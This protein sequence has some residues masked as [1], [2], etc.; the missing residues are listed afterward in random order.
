VLLT[1]G[2]CRRPSGSAGLLTLASLK[3][4]APAWPVGVAVPHPGDHVEDPE[5]GYAQVQF[6]LPAEVFQLEQDYRFLGAEEVI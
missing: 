1:A 4:W 6:G 3:T 5:Q 2:R